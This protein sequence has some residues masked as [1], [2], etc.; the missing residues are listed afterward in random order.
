MKHKSIRSQNNKKIGSLGYR[1]NNDLPLLED[2]TLRRTPSDIARKALVCLALSASSY[3]F[4]KDKARDWLHR[5]SLDSFLDEEEIRFLRGASEKLDYKWYPET[6]WAFMYSLGKVKEIDIA[7]PCPSNL[8]TMLPN[9]N[10]D[11]S[12]KEFLENTRLV[13]TER[14][15]EMLDL[16]YAL[17]SA[18]RES[19]KKDS[20]SLTDLNFTRMR[21]LAFEW[22]FSKE[23]MSEISLDT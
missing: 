1:V 14:L 17:H 8:V 12:P 3:G 15:F 18:I 5:N 11:E 23:D 22:M 19:K 10:K 4:N 7:K 2:V 6:I 13:S 9:L 21:R 16:L 20:K